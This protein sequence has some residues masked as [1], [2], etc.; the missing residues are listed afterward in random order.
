MAKQRGLKTFS[1]L[2]LLSGSS[3]YVYYQQF[4]LINQSAALVTNNQPAIQRNSQPIHRLAL[5]DLLQDNV[6]WNNDCVKNIYI[7]TSTILFG[8]DGFNDETVFTEKLPPQDDKKYVC[9]Q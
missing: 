9:I 8:Y 6:T 7:H 2:I 1:L 5:A 3:F 4:V